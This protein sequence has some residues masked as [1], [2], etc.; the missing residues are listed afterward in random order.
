MSNFTVLHITDVPIEVH[1]RL[2]AK[3]AM[4][5][6]PMYDYIREILVKASEDRVEEAMIEETIEAKDV[7]LQPN[8]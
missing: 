1:S 6:K 3:A 8:S 7:E 5:R 2:K 4:I